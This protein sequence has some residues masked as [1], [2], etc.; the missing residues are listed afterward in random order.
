MKKKY[1]AAIRKWDTETGGGS[2]EHW[3]FGRFCNRDTWLVWVYLMDKRAGFLLFSIAKGK[4]P[5]YVGSEPGTEHL[6]HLVMGG[7]EN[8]I[9]GSED[10]TST[11]ESTPVISGYK[12]RKLTSSES[13]RK[14]NQARQSKVDALLE[15]AVGLIEQQ[16]LPP[17]PATKNELMEE[18]VKAHKN[19]RLAETEM[20]L[21]T[22]SPSSKRVVLSIAK[23]T[24]A[25]LT[26]KLKEAHQQPHIDEESD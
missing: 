26:R 19:L 9:A 24:V 15:A 23:E 21:S 2:H 20:S 8:G 12:K 5:E 25:Q 14:E 13:N 22:M 1:K 6:R 11:D 4:P 3:Q 17:K 7:G 10:T 16:K 18:M